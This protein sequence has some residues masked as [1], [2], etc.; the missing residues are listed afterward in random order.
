MSRYELLK[1]L[2]YSNFIVT[3]TYLSYRLLEKAT[4]LNLALQNGV[5]L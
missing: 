1:G 2:F 5:G 3:D 4:L